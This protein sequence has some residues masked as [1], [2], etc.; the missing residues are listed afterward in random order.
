MVHDGKLAK[1]V[2][3]LRKKHPHLFSV[4]SEVD[5]LESAFEQE[6]QVLRLG[7]LVDHHFAFVESFEV[8]DF[9]E[10][11]Q[12]HPGQCAQ[13]RQTLQDVNSDSHSLIGRALDKSV[14]F[15]DF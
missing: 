10:L 4:D 3:R 1:E 13:Q 2:A 6:K 5:A 9:G 7:P 14:I 15:H 11:R 12:G 8:T